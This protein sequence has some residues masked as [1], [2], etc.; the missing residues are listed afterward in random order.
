MQIGF[1]LSFQVC[2]LK[3]PFKWCFQNY[4]CICRNVQCCS[5]EYFCS[6]EFPCCAWGRMRNVTAMQYLFR[7]LCWSEHQLYL[8]GINSEISQ[9]I[10]AFVSIEEGSVLEPHLIPNITFNKIRNICPLEGFLKPREATCVCPLYLQASEW[11][12]M[13]FLRKSV[14]MFPTLKEF[15]GPLKPP[16][17]GSP[18]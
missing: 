18:A 16:E 15:W 17:G 12:L 9:Y 1:I 11:H 10:W 5:I 3:T 14:V 2:Y 7:M 13:I 4:Y 6:F 8:I